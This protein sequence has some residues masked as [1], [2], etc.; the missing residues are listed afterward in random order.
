METRGETSRQALL[1][2]GVTMLLAGGFSRTSVDD[3]ARA[4]G[5]PKGSFYYYFKTK[6]VL[7]S[8]AVARYAD[9]DAVQRDRMLTIDGPALDRLRR[10][11]EDI[12][13]ALE[14]KGFAGGCLF[15]NLGLEA[16]DHSVMLRDTISDGLAKWTE[17]I[18]AVIAQAI[19]A[20]DVRPGVAAQDS[21]WEGALLRA[22][23][24]Q[25]ARP[26]RAVLDAAFAILCRPA[27]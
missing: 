2:A 24:E 18:A 15:G 11:F 4:A 19:A 13:D 26:L 10:Y 6:E 5:V 3:I 9:Q 1:D 22:R 23:V 14:T 16:A 7:A 21:A 17:V 25:S 27:D 12:I 8:A 20:G